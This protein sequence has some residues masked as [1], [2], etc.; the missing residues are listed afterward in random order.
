MTFTLACGDVMPGCAMR[1][2]SSS[3]DE[4]MQQVAAHARAD[5]GI[6]EVTPEIAEAVDGK[7][8]TY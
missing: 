2:E 4:L 7:I 1:F 5:H 8:L 3:K 6:E